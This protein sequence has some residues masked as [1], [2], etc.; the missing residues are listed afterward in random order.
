MK[1]SNFAEEQANRFITEL[2]NLH[3]DRS[4]LLTVHLLTEHWLNELISKNSPTSKVILEKFEFSQK[5]I[6][7]YNMKLIPDQLYENIVILNQIRNK[8]AHDLDF[9]ITSDRGRDFYSRLHSIPEEKIDFKLF[10]AAISNKRM[11][12]KDIIYWI[13][14]A[15]FGWLHNLCNNSN[16]SK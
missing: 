9:A 2:K 1:M 4:I 13:S 3:D 8:F 16:L 7:I 6:L 5:I 11:E 10:P 15:T 14:I 12:P